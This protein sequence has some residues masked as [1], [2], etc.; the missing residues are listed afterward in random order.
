MKH[1]CGIYKVINYQFDQLACLHLF[2]MINSSILKRMLRFFFISRYEF[3]KWLFCTEKGIIMHALTIRHFYIMCHHLF[4]ARRKVIISFWSYFIN[5][6]MLFL[7]MVSVWNRLCIFNFFFNVRLKQGLGHP[8]WFTLGSWGCC[9]CCFELFWHLCKVDTS[10]KHP[11][12]VFIKKKKTLKA[13]Y[14]HIS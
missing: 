13:L 1:L 3:I 5:E 2:L 4:Y 6:W 7:W 8:Q 11:V 9:F 10:T 12:F 14:Q